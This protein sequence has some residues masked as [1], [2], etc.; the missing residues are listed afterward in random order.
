M[1]S[2]TEAKAVAVRAGH[3]AQVYQK[4]DK[5]DDPSRLKVKQTGVEDAHRYVVCLKEN[6][7]TKDRHGQ[8]GGGGLAA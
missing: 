1:R 3:Y 2:S 4:S 8:R 7:A 6:Q 5:R